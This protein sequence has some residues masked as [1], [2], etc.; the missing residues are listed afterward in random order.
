MLSVTLSDSPTLSAIKTTHSSERKRNLSRSTDT[1]H[2]ECNNRFLCFHSLPTSDV[3]RQTSILN[4]PRPPQN[5]SWRPSPLHAASPPRPT[6]SHA[7]PHRRSLTR[8][9]S[10]ARRRRRCDPRSRSPYGAIPPPR[11]SSRMAAQAHNHHHTHNSG[12]TERRCAT[13]TTS[14]PKAHPAA[15][16]EMGA[17]A[18]RQRAVAACPA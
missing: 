6:R 17:Q 15:E 7:S 4:P 3:S 16:G 2:K 12:G 9:A 8:R 10:A 1:E 11:P 18:Q 14:N 5:T 13:T